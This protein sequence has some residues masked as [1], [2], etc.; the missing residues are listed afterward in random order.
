MWNTTRRR[1]SEGHVKQGGQTVP[2]VGYLM[3]GRGGKEEEAWSARCIAWALVS[4]HLTSASPP[5]YTSLYIYY[6]PAY[7][8]N[9]IAYTN[10]YPP[11][12]FV[13]KLAKFIL[14]Y[15][16]MFG[17]DGSDREESNGI[18]TPTKSNRNNSFESIRFIWF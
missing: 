13:Y 5:P 10:H 7:Y 15:L 17:K 14:L 1:E 18:K 3:V 4:P 6:T 2:R 9:Q 12:F 11:N 16:N 8:F